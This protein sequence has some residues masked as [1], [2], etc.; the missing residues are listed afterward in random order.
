METPLSEFENVRLINDRLGMYSDHE[1]DESGSTY[2]FWVEGRESF[3]SHSERAI[4]D[5]QQAIKV[6]RRLQRLNRKRAKC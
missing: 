4:E 2:M 5:H 6:W 3:E 1:G